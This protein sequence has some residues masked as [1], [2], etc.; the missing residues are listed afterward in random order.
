[1]SIGPAQ[2][3][4][5]LRT[6]LA[7]GADRAI[8]VEVDEAVEPLRSIGHSVEC[9][10]VSGLRSEPARPGGDEV[11]LQQNLANRFP[12]KSPQD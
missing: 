1:M 5:T 3:A 6:A 2:A 12:P 11:L 9:Q 10:M 7:M 8:L 4:E